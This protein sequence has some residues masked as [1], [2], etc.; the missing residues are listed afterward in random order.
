MKF[1][2]LALIHLYRRLVRPF[3]R[4]TCLFRESC[5]VCVERETRKN[6]FRAGLKAL[7]FRFQNC[8][9]GYFW[10]HQDTNPQ[11]VTATGVVLDKEE[12]NPELMNDRRDFS[13]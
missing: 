5:S 7:R 4:A 6:G 9:P 13:N 8:R 2:L 3:T 11:L 12:V 1:L 10:I